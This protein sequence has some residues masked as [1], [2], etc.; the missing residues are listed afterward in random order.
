[1]QGYGF[2]GQFQNEND[3][4]RQFE[5]DDG[6]YG[7]G[8]GKRSRQGGSQGKK[9]VSQLDPPSAFVDSILTIY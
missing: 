2:T 1:M 4:K 8:K 5:Q 7:F 9:P 3:R 6:D